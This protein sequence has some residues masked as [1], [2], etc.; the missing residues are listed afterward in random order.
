LPDLIK[1]AGLKST[2][3]KLVDN[4]LKATEFARDWRNRLIA[5]RDLDIALSTATTPLKDASRAQ[6]KD[7]LASLAAG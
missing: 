5:H 1:D 2:V 4:A 7:A 6:V 3:A